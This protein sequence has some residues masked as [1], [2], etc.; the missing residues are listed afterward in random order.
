MG[1]DATISACGRYRYTL[2]RRWGSGSS[3]VLW[4]MLNPS[5]A[6]A[7]L[8]DPTIRR[9]IAFS[10]AW[11]RD[12]LTVCNL[13]ALRTTYPAELWKCADP[14]GPE[15]DKHIVRSGGDVIVCAWGANAK[16]DRVTAFFNLMSGMAPMLCLGTTK[17]GAPRH[18]LYVAGS[19]PL[20]PWR[21]ASGRQ[22]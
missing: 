4:V 3:S 6:D 2:T 20:Q 5:T 22:S 12:A 14:V 9:C 13:Y 17:A 11:G 21:P 10:K 18:P 1:G 15:N 7:T 8:D 19:T 16:A